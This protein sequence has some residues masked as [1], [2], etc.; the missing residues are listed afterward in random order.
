[1][2][3]TGW[4]D[5]MAPFYAAADLAVQPTF[6]DACSLA[7]LESLASGLPV[8]TTRANGGSELL[9][10]GVDGIVLDDAEQ[11]TS[12]V[13]SPSRRSYRSTPKWC[14]PGVDGSKRSL[15]PTGESPEAVFTPG[16]GENIQRA[17]PAT[18]RPVDERRAAP[19]RRAGS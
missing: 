2:V 3:E 8:V 6:Y 10:P 5:D 15:L 14:P 19:A 9:T 16:P 18:L 17:G 1:V 4:V 7:T 13:T 11:R 12:R